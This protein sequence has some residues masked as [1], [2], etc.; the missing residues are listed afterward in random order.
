MVPPVHG[1]TTI[2]DMPEMWL[3]KS[4]E[5]IVN[6]RFSLVRGVSSVDIHNPS[7]KYVESLQ[8]LAMTSKPVE[9][10]ITFEKAPIADVEQAKEFG[11]F[12]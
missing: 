7:G 12:Y 5:E 11:L 1:D 3:G 8:E 4:L 9:S 6:Y 10:E 2:L